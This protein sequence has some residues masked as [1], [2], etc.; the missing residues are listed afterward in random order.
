MRVVAVTGVSGLIGQRLLPLLEA[1]PGVERIIG[2]DVKEPSRR[3]NLL[4]MHLVDVTTSL[5]TPLLEGVDTLIHLASV[6]GPIQ[7]AAVARSVN[8]DGTR[9]VLAAATEAGVTRILRASTAAV[10]G[11]WAANPIPLTESA[12][13]RT[14]PGYEPANED[15]EC[16]RL[17]GD[18]QLANPATTVT[19]LRVAPVVGAGARGVF[20]RAAV[21]RPPAVVRGYAPPVQVVHVDD[22]A[23]A[24]A[25]AIE[26]RLEGVYN[27]AADGWLDHDDAIAVAPHRRPPAVPYDMAHKALSAMWASGVGDA[28]PEVLPYVMHSWAISNELL[29]STGW[30]AKHT[31]EEAI[32]L[33]GDPDV[34][35]RP[36]PWIAAVGAVVSG[37]AGATWW[38]T[39]RRRG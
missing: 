39:R 15:A 33:A 18:W 3:V 32:L 16:E 13:L 5:V 22:V 17:I 10:Y 23:S 11:A 27:V 24:I 38:L 8:I 7:D 1:I 2:I 21:G 20:A 36:L 31:N 12:M 28:P 25:H 26:Q 6:V 37:A 19:C 4:E 29:K 9:R 34:R 30:S 14:N 35:R